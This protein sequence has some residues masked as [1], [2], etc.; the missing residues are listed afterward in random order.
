MPSSPAHRHERR[1]RSAARVTGRATRAPLVLAVDVGATKTLLLVGPVAAPSGAG[2]SAEQTVARFPTERDPDRLVA[3]IAEE[4]VGREAAL[5]GRIVAVGCAAPGPL[6]RAGG[7]VIHSPNLSWRQVPLRSMLESRLG[8]PARLD[9]DAAAGALG[10]AR[11]G[12]GRGA[13]PF[14]FLTVSSGVGMGIVVG[15]RPV[16]GAHGLAGEIGHLTV[17][18]AGPRCGCGR[19]GDVESYLGG[20]SLA[21]RAR[22]AWGRGLLADGRPAPRDAD[23]VFQA[24]RL[25]DAI[26]RALVDDAAEALGRALAAVAAV[27]DPERIAV[28]G[29]LGLGQPRLVRRA[30][31]IAR[32]RCMAETGRSLTVVPPELGEACVLAG[33]MAIAR[34]L[35]E[36][37]APG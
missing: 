27:L 19:R 24:A 17:D 9:D 21:R 12:A 20:A 4:A 5:G 31:V 28:G 13:D 32:R 6:D 36:V 26:A 18:P 3:R 29:A 34:D 37:D 14:A 8:V 2:W 16:H 23:G 15:G 25:G 30:T 10:E 22:Q 11:A 35:A 33:A 1:G 7:V